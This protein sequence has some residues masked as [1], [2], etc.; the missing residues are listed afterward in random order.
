MD[1]LL[2]QLETDLRTALAT[3]VTGFVTTA[4][5]TLEAAQADIVKERAEGLAEVARR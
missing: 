5:A 1:T 2:S 3:C 4:R